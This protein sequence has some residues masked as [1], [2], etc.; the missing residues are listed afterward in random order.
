MLTNISF[1][2]IMIP[3]IFLFF[4]LSSIFIWLKSRIKRDEEILKNFDHNRVILEYNMEKAYD[5]IHKDEILIYSLEA[6]KLPDEDFDRVTKEFVKLVEKILGPRLVKHFV[7][8][9]GNYE[10]FLFNI[11]EFFN[12]K[13]EEDSIREAAQRDLM[14]TDIDT[15]DQKL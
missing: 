14:E 13:Y 8:M 15:G 11:V 12:S 10:T 7:F 2:I 5:L 1:L 4:I 9:Y 6:T 3:L